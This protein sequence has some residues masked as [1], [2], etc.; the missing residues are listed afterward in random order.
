[1]YYIFKKNDSLGVDTAAASP[2][3]LPVNTRAIAPE[4]TFRG[5]LLPGR[6]V[7]LNL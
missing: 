4:F 6:E 7:E 1:V 2:Y 5:F 3:P